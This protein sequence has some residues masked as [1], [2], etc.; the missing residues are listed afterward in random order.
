MIL[1]LN[2]SF[3]VKRWLEPEIL[4]A[5]VGDELGVRHV[6]FTFDLIDPWW[7]EGFRDELAGRYK[8][9]FSEKGV[10]IDAAFGGLASYTYPQFLSPFPDGRTA[11]LEFFE[12]SVDMTLALGA[13]IVGTPVGGM[14]NRDASDPARSLDRYNHMLDGVKA[15]A[16]YG[17]RKGLEEIHI[18]ATPLIT[19]FPYSPEAALKLMKDLEG[20]AIPVKLLVDWGHALY[21]PLLGAEADIDL[22]FSKCGPHIGSI[23]L[24]QTD[25]LLDRHWD[26]TSQGLVSPKMI[27]EAT[28]KASLDKVPQYLEVVP[29]FESPDDEVLDKVKRSVALLREEFAD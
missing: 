1:G 29:A 6:Q 4:A 2:L 10:S 24:Q 7:P 22:W 9:A 14:S 28:L 18:E 27:K 3:A 8:E 16:A 19:E 20:S 21:K 5:L 25:G 23:H 11:A 12:R 26:F 13:K 17:K 15:L